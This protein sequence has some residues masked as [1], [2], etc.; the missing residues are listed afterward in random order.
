MV[1]TYFACFLLVLRVFSAKRTAKI[2]AKP[3]IT[4]QP[5]KILTKP[6]TNRD[7]VADLPSDYAG[8]YPPNLQ[9][10]LIFGS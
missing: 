3:E 9:K 6:Y 7:P 5:S 1:E 2:E 10:A 4:S 8:F